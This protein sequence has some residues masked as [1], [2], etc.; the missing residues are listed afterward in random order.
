MKTLYIK[1][2]FDDWLDVAKKALNEQKT[3]GDVIL[4]IIRGYFDKQV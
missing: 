3:R 1:F 2:P 4:E